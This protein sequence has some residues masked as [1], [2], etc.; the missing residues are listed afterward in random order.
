M[1]NENKSNND[2]CVVYKISLFDF[3]NLLK[4][5]MKND[6]I[7]RQEYVK[8]YRRVPTIRQKYVEGFTLICKIFIPICDTM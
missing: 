2:T 5:E 8:N 1:N 6:L 3:P 4:F 7:N